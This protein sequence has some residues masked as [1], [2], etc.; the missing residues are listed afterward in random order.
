MGKNSKIW[1]PRSLE[2]KELKSN[3]F[4]IQG[5]EIQEIKNPRIWNPIT[6]ESK[7]LKSNKSTIQGFEIQ[8]L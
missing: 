6:L 8:E 7:N 5:F 4:R 1:N 2:S 3:K